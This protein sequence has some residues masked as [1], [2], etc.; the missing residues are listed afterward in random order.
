MV[1]RHR[2]I[3][4]DMPV[5]FS[6]QYVVVSES[7]LVRHFNSEH[8][9][10]KDRCPMTR[11]TLHFKD[12]SRLPE[13][14]D[15]TM[16]R[17]GKKFLRN[18]QAIRGFKICLRVDDQFLGDVDMQRIDV[19]L[20]SSGI[21]VTIRRCA[22][23]C[24]SNPIRDQLGIVDPILFV[25]AAP[26]S[27]INRNLERKTVLLDRPEAE[28]A[29]ERK[30]SSLLIKEGRDALLPPLLSSDRFIHVMN[31]SQAETNLTFA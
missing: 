12:F 5:D 26:A 28:K 22:S 18:L 7:A 11:S 27:V 13:D 8:L 14:D 24:K 4:E 21:E 17:E 3:S 6:A 25:G 30:I 15:L 19:A 29:K 9:I 20:R 10:R 1:F 16:S 31:W 23:Y 2:V